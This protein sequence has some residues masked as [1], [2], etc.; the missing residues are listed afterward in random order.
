MVSDVEINSVVSKIGRSAA[1]NDFSLA[2]EELACVADE[3]NPTGI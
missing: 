1:G 2:R 3:L